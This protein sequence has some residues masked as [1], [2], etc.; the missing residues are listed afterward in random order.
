MTPFPSKG[1]E[2]P[3]RSSANQDAAPD[4]G[5]AVARQ[6]RLAAHFFEIELWRCEGA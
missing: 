6:S 2:S 5:S 3:E 4:L 1:G